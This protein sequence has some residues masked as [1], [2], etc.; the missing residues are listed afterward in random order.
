METET[1]RCLF[2]DQIVA[3]K[4]KGMDDWYI[5]CNCS[6]GGTYALDRASYDSYYALSYSEK[7]QLFPV[8][9]AY[10]REMTDCDEQVRLSYKDIQ[11]FESSPIIPT[12][13]EEKGIKLL[14]YL[15]R[16]CS[17][18][19][20]AVVIHQLS[21]SYN[22]TYSMNLQE[23]VYII[24]KLKGE[25]YIERVGGKFWLTDKGWQEAVLCAGGQ[26]LKPCLLLVSGTSEQRVEWPEELF[27]K[28]EQCGYLPRMMEITDSGALN[29]Q[30]MQLISESKLLIADVSGQASLACFAAGYALGVDV[31][32]L[33]VVHS[34]DANKMKMPFDRIRPLIWDSEESLGQMLEQQLAN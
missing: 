10:I 3:V 9:S 29:A 17:K 13:I 18:P 30:T 34:A 24:E 8:I 23:L 33:W 21:S 20:E 32:V 31:P 27:P 25:E 1:K 2:C 12:T 16:H 22:L 4:Q 26:R 19:G 11:M 15:H 5:S 7:R 6:P 28:L 14:R